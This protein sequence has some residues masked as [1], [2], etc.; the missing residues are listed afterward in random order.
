MTSKK[1]PAVMSKPSKFAAAL[2]FSSDTPAEQPKERTVRLNAEIPEELHRKVKRE[3][4]RRGLS[5]KELLLEMIAT[6]L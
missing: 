6:H 2:E 4:A 1:A 3:A 5:V